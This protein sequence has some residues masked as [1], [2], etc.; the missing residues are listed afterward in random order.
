MVRVGRVY[1]RVLGTGMGLGGYGG[2]V[3]RYLAQLLG[4]GPYPSEAGPVR[5]AGPG[6]GGDM[7]PGVRPALTTHSGP[8]GSSGARFAVRA[9]LLEQVP[10]K[11]V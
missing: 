1:G 7:E 5:P 6:V 9:S 8:Q 3:Y 2:G 4:E 10:H 11:A